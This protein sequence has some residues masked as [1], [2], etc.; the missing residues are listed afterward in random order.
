MRRLLFRVA[1]VRFLA[2]VQSKT[3]ISTWHGVPEC[4]VPANFMALMGRG[5][6]G[7]ERPTKMCQRGLLSVRALISRPIFFAIS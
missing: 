7:D 4:E 5:R 3:I 6:A 1:C 2:E